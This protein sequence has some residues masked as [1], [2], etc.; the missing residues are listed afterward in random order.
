MRPG[1]KEDAS[2]PISR[3]QIARVDADHLSLAVMAFSRNMEDQNVPLLISDFLQYFGSHDFQAGVVLLLIHT[4]HFQVSFGAQRPKP[5]MLIL[6]RFWFLKD[7][8]QMGLK[9]KE[10]L[11]NC[12]VA[13][14][15]SAH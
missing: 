7:L 11:R 9:R 13:A 8:P 4:R 10:N 2:K 5:S 14:G 3:L 1:R 15:R 12:E 6:R